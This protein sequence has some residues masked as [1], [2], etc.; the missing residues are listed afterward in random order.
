MDISDQLS[1]AARLTWRH[2]T[3]WWLGLLPGLTHIATSLAQLWFFHYARREF[4]PLLSQLPPNGP[5][6]EQW[7]FTPD[8]VEKF[9]NVPVLIGGIVWLF[10]VGIL[11]WLLLVWAEAAIIAATMGI[12]GEKPLSVG[13]SLASGRRFLGRFVAIDALLFFPWF[14]LA[15][16]AMVI[17]ALTVTSTAVLAVNQS[18]ATSLFSALGL[19]LSCA[20]LLACLLIPVSFVTLR[21]RTMVYRDAVINDAAPTSERPIR[22]TVRHAW[23]VIRLNLAEVLILMAILWGMQYVFNLLLSAVSLPLGLASA[24]SILIGLVTAVLLAIPQALLF[25]Y[26]GVVWTLAYWEW[27]KE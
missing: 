26:V 9:F 21:F 7:L 14:L 1:R 5:P 11:F 22:H 24:A 18:T 20:G 12:V 2:K 8:T 25:V 3:L 17:L 27:N 16:A 4:L 15:L 10:L 23:Q 13:E 19:G 6:L